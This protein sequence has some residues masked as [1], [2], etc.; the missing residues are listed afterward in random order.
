ME[1]HENST[2]IVILRNIGE[3]G[4]INDVNRYVSNDDHFTNGHL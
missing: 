1:T 2:P 3:T 4:D